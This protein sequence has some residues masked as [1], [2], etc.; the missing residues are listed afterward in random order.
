[1]CQSLPAQP[2]LLGDASQL[3]VSYT[4]RPV[5]CRLAARAH[6]PLSALSFLSHGCSLPGL[7]TLLANS[8]LPLAEALQAGVAARPPAEG[9]PRLVLF[10]PEAHA[11]E[12]CRALRHAAPPLAS[13][14]LVSLTRSAHAPPPVCPGLQ[15]STTLAA[16]DTGA[17]ARPGVRAS[18]GAPSRRHPHPGGARLVARQ[19]DTGRAKPRGCRSAEL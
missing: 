14:T 7:P 19:D 4:P 2:A 1:L 13:A 9:S 11:R 8:Y 17:E 15:R 18:A 10:A 6:Q 3:S 16:I 5:S 12:A